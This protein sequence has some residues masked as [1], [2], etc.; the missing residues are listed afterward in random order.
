MREIHIQ[1][2]CVWHRNAFRLQVCSSRLSICHRL[3]SGS[4]TAA[5]RATELTHAHDTQSSS[6]KTRT[7]TSQSSYY[8]F[9]R[10]WEHVTAWKNHS[11]FNKS[12]SLLSLRTTH[13]QQ[14]QTQ[15]RFRYD[16]YLT[17][18]MT[19][20]LIP[21]YIYINAIFITILG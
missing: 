19:V 1:I 12:L 18:H 5:A 11:S 8:C 7:S 6:I 16:K 13:S 20:N 3:H 2:T 4:S 9:I 21:C 15:T 14:E 17:S 10:H